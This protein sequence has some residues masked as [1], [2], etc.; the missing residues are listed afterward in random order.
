M[1]AAI[2]LLPLPYA[3]ALVAGAGALIVLSI[4]P[5]LGLWL[6]VFSVPYGSLKQGGADGLDLS[7]TEPIVFVVL[8]FWLMRG[9]RERRIKIEP[10]ALYAPLLLFLALVAFSLTTAPSLVLAAKELFKWTALLTIYALVV[11]NVGNRHQV[12]V[13][14]S[15]IFI[16]AFSESILGFYQFVAKAGPPGFAIGPFLRAF[17]TFGQPNPYAG[18]L[19]MVVAA[20]FGLVLFSIKAI[21]TASSSAS[22]SAFF[23]TP[24]WAK[25]LVITGWLTF[26]A[27]I[28]AIGMSLSRGA[29]LGLAVSV[30]VMTT[31]SN[32]RVL[33]V[34]LVLVAIVALVLALGLIQ[35]LPA[36]FVDRV[37]EAVAYF[38]VF[39]ARQVKVTPENWPLVERM[40]NWQ[41]AWSMYEDNPVIGVGIGNYVEA[42]E[43]FHLPG[44]DEPKGHAHN[45]YLNMLAEMG[46]LGLAAYLALL[47]SFLI[48]GFRVQRRLSRSS[49]S[50]IERHIVIGLI[51]ALVAMA[52]HNTFDNLFVHG[53]GV[54]MGIILGLIAVLDR[55]GQQRPVQGVEGS[56]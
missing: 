3:G 49:A 46:I 4:K 17:G 30:V 16:A 22:S 27:G 9:L 6:L 1:T 37:S 5:D 8:A 7:L 14:L 55:I 39:D 40:A 28:A 50:V 52:V 29:W 48:Q 35:A 54:Q 25:W 18:Y 38:G 51:G 31:L 12:V 20:A 45:I 19:A 26:G 2:A 21:F 41:A 32:R 23:G 56:A 43:R 42:Y 47:A 11:S 33:W 24:P 10:A 44:W 15:L 13:L 53:L 34:I 36:Q